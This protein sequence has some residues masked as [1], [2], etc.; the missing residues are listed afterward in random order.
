MDLAAVRRIVQIGD[1]IERGI[2]PIRFLWMVPAQ[3]KTLGDFVKVAQQREIAEERNV[4]C[5]ITCHERRG[6]E[7]AR[8]DPPEQG[9][10]HPQ[11]TE[12]ATESHVRLG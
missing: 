9:V 5:D 2:C 3:E 1:A 11:P 12:Q 6:S 7:R 4:R 10:G 8:P